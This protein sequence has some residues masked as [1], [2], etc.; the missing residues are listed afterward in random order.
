MI[1][2]RASHNI[3]IVFLKIS[4]IDTQSKLAYNFIVITFSYISHGNE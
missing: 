3:I 1:H 4:I 2:L